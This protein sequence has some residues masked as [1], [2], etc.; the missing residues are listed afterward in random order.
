MNSAQWCL[1]S[2][3]ELEQPNHSR[4]L[5]RTTAVHS[6][7]QLHWRGRL[8]ATCTNV[9][10]LDK[11]RKRHTAVDITL[12]YLLSETFGNQRHADQQQE[13]ERQH[14]HRGVT[15]NELINRRRRHKHHANS[16]SNRNNHHRHICRHANSSDHRVDRKHHVEN[17]H[18]A[19]NSRQSWRGARR[20]VFDFA[21]E[22]VVNFFGR[23]IY[24]EVALYR[25]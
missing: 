20:R 17:Q 15:I 9:E 19:N 24:E 10:Q 2:A 21:L 23:P 16:R 14:L 1:K 13:G 25:L 18:L 4:Q 5:S 7:M 22:F 11:N 3:N 8:F 12:G 6:V